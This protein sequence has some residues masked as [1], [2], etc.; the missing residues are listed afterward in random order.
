[1]QLAGNAVQFEEKKDRR[2]ALFEFLAQVTDPRGRV[3]G[4][5][6]D[7]VQVRLPIQTAERI[8]TGA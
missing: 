5:A 1:M 3:A 7:M 4:I 2:E 8:R 6:R